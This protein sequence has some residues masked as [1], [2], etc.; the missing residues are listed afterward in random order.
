MACRIETMARTY[1]GRK[2]LFALL[3]RFVADRWSAIVEWAE[4][5]SPGVDDGGFPSRPVAWVELPPQGFGNV[6]STQVLL[7]PARPVAARKQAVPLHA[8]VHFVVDEA[9]DDESFDQP[10]EVD[11]ALTLPAAFAKLSGQITPELAGTGRET[12]HVCEGKFL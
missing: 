11:L 7:D 10:V 6:G 4:A 8:S 1:H 5:T 2:P 12:G 3:L 9:F